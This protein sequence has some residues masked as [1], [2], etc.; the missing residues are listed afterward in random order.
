MLISE[1][2]LWKD[3]EKFFRHVK[4]DETVDVK[5]NRLKHTCVK[6]KKS[7]DF[8]ESADCVINEIV[9]VK[10]GETQFGGFDENVGSVRSQGRTMYDPVERFRFWIELAE[11]KGKIPPSLLKVC[12]N[13][14]SISELKAFLQQKQNRKYRK[15]YGSILKNWDPDL[16]KEL[17]SEEKQS[18]EINFHH[19]LRI[20]KNEN[21]R[22]KKTGR[23]KSLPH[24]TFLIEI[25]LQ[26]IGRADL[27]LNFLPMK[28]K[29]IRQEYEML[30]NELFSYFHLGFLFVFDVS[31]RKDRLLLRVSIR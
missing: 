4:F 8:V 30:I 21:K 27:A 19:L 12:D 22:N 24:Y 29:K 28:C 26:K 18:L 1:T 10:C 23:K 20:H 13:F 9:C 5:E 2:E 11:G 6:C 25:F 15:F 7:D 14:T 17:S 16:I 31:L 3:F